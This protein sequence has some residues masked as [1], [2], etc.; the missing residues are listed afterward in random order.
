MAL[1]VEDR[2]EVVGIVNQEVGSQFDIWVQALLDV[3][4]ARS[5]A[6]VTVINAGGS[7]AYA[8]E[9]LTWLPGEYHEIEVD[10]HDPFLVRDD[11]MRGQFASNGAGDILSSSTG[12]VHRL[13]TD[14]VV[15][16]D[17]QDEVIL[18]RDSDNAAY[19][20]FGRTGRH[21]V[22]VR[23][24]TAAPVRSDDTLT[25]TGTAADPLGVAPGAPAPPP[26]AEVSSDAEVARELSSGPLSS[27]S[28]DDVTRIHNALD[29]ARSMILPRIKDSAQGD[30][31]VARA[32]TA[33]AARVYKMNADRGAGDELI[34]PE[35]LVNKSIRDML[36]GKW[37]IVM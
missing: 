15:S 11:Y 6:Q 22:S 36:A 2:A 3:L 10:A 21:T 25:G 23:R 9:G 31:A 37:K 35:G 34:V 7:V 27:Y 14:S 19:I 30:I 1:T 26:G 32:V 33:I 24:L 20:Q 29:T 18:G 13:A 17:A 5:D 8:I 4:F 28:E 12:F 16:A